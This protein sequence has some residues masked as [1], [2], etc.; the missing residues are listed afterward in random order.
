MTATLNYISKDSKVS[1]MR[2]KAVA[3]NTVLDESTSSRESLGKYNNVKTVRRG[4]GVGLEGWG[5]PK[6]G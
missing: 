1:K 4:H 3:R 6:E 2:K 5:E